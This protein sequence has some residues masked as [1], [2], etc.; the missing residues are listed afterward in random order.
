MAYAAREGL[1]FAGLPAFGWAYIT[2][3]TPALQALTDVVIKLRRGSRLRGY[4]HYSTDL[5]SVFIRVNL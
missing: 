3:I 2:R 4:A 1:K 5:I